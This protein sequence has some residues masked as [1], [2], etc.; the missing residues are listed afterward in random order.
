MDLSFSTLFGQDSRPMFTLPGL[1]AI[2]VAQYTKA[3][4]ISSWLR[5]LPVMNLLYLAAGF[6][7]LL[8]I[9]LGIVRAEACPQLRLVLPLW[10][11]TLVSVALTGGL[12]V[13]QATA[14]MIYMLLFL[15]IAQGVQSFRGLRLVALSI[16]TISLFLGVVAFIQALNPFQCQLLVASASGD[17]AG[18]PDGRACESA[19]ECREG[20]ETGEDFICERPGPFSTNSVGHGRVRYR[21]IL[22]DPNELALV[23][24]I[25]LPFA[26]T[27]FAQRRSLPSLLLLIA[28]FAITLPVVVWTGSRTGQLAFVAVVA[29]YVIQR[30][31]VKGILA[32]AVLAAPALLLGGRS[33]DEADASSMERLE[34]WSAGMDMFKSSPIWGIGKSQFIEHHNITAHNTFVLESAELGLIGIALWVG[35][36]YTSF[37]IVLLAVGRYRSRP[38]G[39][40]PYAW[41]RALLASLCGIAVGTSFL[42]LGYHPVVWAFLALPG[43]YYLAVRR[44]DPEFRVV[45]GARDLLAVTGF[46][47]LYLAGLKGYLMVR[48]V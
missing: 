46:A 48:G 2:L 28:A 39:T 15:L 19:A 10:M 7:L 11:W 38:D 8:D 16:L 6:G 13:P 40:L 25:A 33:G 43:A 17:S 44:H 30:V 32:A 24:V 45:F 3:N 27:T 31:G 21:G 42:S 29:V 36:F 12:I 41:A 47:L 18:R 14:T 20:A 4:E 26:M 37:K 23:L 35:V 34:A 9:R 1:L 5:P 22:E